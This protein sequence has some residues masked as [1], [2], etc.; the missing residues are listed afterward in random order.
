[1][2]AKIFEERRPCVA[3]GYVPQQ[4]RCVSGFSRLVFV[5][6]PSVWVLRKGTSQLLYA[7][8][9]REGGELGCFSLSPSLP[10]AEKLILR[11]VDLLQ[12][13]QVMLI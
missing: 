10:V 8:L 5:P 4:Q 3:L 12:P 11:R 13:S 2:S 7:A 9:R 1:M 6:Y